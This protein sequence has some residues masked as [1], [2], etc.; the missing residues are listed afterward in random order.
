MDTY[1]RE[2]LQLSHFI[3]IPFP[4]K[5]IVVVK[6]KNAKHPGSP[7][8]KIHILELTLTMC[9]SPYIHTNFNETR[10]QMDCQ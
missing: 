9:V 3:P 5:I 2:K 7:P 6:L 4:T 8:P 10:I 1:L